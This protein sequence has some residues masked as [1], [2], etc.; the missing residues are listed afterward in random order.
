MITVFDLS[1]YDIDYHSPLQ[2]RPLARRSTRP[3]AA[4]ISPNNWHRM[5]VAFSSSA[6]ISRRRPACASLRTKKSPLSLFDK[7]A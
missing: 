6:P 2:R 3:A 4:P 5:S 1:D 7:N